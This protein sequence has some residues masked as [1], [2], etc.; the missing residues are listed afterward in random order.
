MTINHLMK[1]LTHATCS[2]RHNYQSFICAEGEQ[3]P[4]GGA[5]LLPRPRSPLGK[6]LLIKSQIHLIFPVVSEGRRHEKIKVTGYCH[7]QRAINF[8]LVTKLMNPC[9]EYLSALVNNYS[10]TNFR[11]QLMS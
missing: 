8:D 6:Q 1:K 11:K 2:E 5:S 7:A 9:S 4:A 10:S 3:N